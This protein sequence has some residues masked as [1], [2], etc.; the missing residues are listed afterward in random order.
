MSGVQQQWA[1]CPFCGSDIDPD[2]GDVGYPR[3]RDMTL[4]IVQCNKCGAAGE[5]EVKTHEECRG[6]WNQRIARA[7]AQQPVAQP[8]KPVAWRWMPSSVWGGFVYSDIPA[9]VEEARGFGVDVQSLYT[10]PPNLPT[11]ADPEALELLR[12]ARSGFANDWWIA[13][14]IDA[15]LAKHAAMTALPKE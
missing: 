10:T 15:Y 3:N 8:A 12:V 14:A 5:F 4:W 6:K 7:E 11:Q 13:K 2:D 1:P 9:K